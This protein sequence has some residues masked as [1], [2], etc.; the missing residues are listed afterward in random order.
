MTDWFL[1]YLHSEIEFAKEHRHP[2]HMRLYCWLTRQKTPAEAV[3]YTL[4][5]LK[6]QYLIT[7]G[8]RTLPAI[9]KELEDSG[10]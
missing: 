4:D 8:D 2:W 5:I 7:R 10:K 1:D 9:M 6:L 3:A